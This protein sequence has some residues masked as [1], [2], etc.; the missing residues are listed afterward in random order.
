ME[1]GEV[2]AGVEEISHPCTLFLHIV[3]LQYSKALVLPKKNKPRNKSAELGEES[4]RPGRTRDARSHRAQTNVVLFFRTFF[5][6]KTCE[7]L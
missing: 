3:K 5:E 4:I 2:K 7:F 6:L 1:I